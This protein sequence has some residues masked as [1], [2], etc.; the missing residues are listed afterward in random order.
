MNKPIRQDRP[1]LPH[2]PPVRPENE[3]CPSCGT[4]FCLGAIGGTCFKA[5]KTEASR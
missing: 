5:K 3:R 2:L 4:H 1:R